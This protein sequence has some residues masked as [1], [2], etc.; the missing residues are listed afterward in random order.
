MKKSALRDRAQRNYDQKSQNLGIA[1]YKRLCGSGMTEDEKIVVQKYTAR[2]D[3][4]LE[5]G[6]GVFHRTAEFYTAL[7][8]QFFGV[9]PLIGIALNGQYFSQTVIEHF[10]PG[11]LNNP[12]IADKTFSFVGC[13]GLVL[14]GIISKERAVDFWAGLEILAHEH[15]AII[16]LDTL[17]APYSS[18]AEEEFHTAQRGKL[19]SSAIGQYFPSRAEI[20]REVKAHRLHIIAEYDSVVMSTQQKLMILKAV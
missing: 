13:F 10:S 3:T 18:N 14:N 16:A 19:H 15:N 1:Q 4:V 9:E 5:I 6:A 7:Q 17:I 8:L 2:G 12:I 20:H 11:S